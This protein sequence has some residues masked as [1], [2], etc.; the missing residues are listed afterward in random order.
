MRYDSFKVLIAMSVSFLMVFIAFTPFTPFTT[1]VDESAPSGT[2]GAAICQGDQCKRPYEDAGQ[3]YTEILSQPTT[4]SSR[5][6]VNKY[7]VLAGISDYPGSGSDLQYCDDDVYD[8]RDKLVELGWSNTNIHLLIDGQ[9]TNQN[10]LSE[11]AWM[12]QQENVNSQV[13]FHF[14]GH[15]N[16]GTFMTYGSTMTDDTLANAFNGFESTQR[17]I[18]MDTCFA[19]SFTSLNMANTISIMACQN[20]QFSYDGVFTPTFVNKMPNASTSVE[21][22]FNDAKT[23]VSQQTG[24]NQVPLMWDN[25]AGNLLLGN[26]PPVIGA[27][28]AFS[29]EEDTPIVMDLTAYESD[30]EDTGPDLDWFVTDYDAGIIISITGEQSDDDVITLYPETD[31]TGSTNIELSLFDSMGQSTDR[32]VSVTWTPVNDPPTVASLDRSKSVLKRT[33]SLVF[34]LFGNDVDDLPNQVTAEIEVSPEGQ[35]EWVPTSSSQYVQGH[36]ETKWTPFETDELGMYDVRARLIDKVGLESDWIVRGSLIEVQNNRPQITSI[37][38][39]FNGVERSGNITLSIYGEDVEDQVDAMTAQLEYL[40]PGGL[41]MSAGTAVLSIG[42]WDVDFAPGIEAPLGWYDLRAQVTDADGDT[43]PWFYEN[44]SIE[45]QNSRP[46]VTSIVPEET[47]V[48]RDS[49]INIEV[50]GWDPEDSNINLLAELQF[51]APDGEWLDMSDTIEFS[52]D[53][54]WATFLPETGYE[55]GQ[56]SFR[57]RLVDTA[58]AI[59]DWYMLEDGVDVLNNIPLVEAIESNTLSV[60]RTDDMEVTIKVMDVEDPIYNLT[61]E[62]ELSPDGKEAWDS[63]IVSSVEWSGAKERWVVILSPDAHVTPGD[64]QLRVRFTDLDGSIGEW[65]VFEE[66]ITIMNGPPVINLQYPDLVNEK[67]DVTFDASGSNDPEGGALQYSWDFGDGGSDSSDKPVHRFKKHGTYYLTL[68]VKDI[69]GAE[70]TETVTLKINGL[71]VAVLDATQDAGIN[72]FL[73]KFTSEGSN[74][75]DGSIAS[76]RWDFDTTKDTNG[77][78]D[79]AN[80]IDSTERNPSYDYEKEGTFTYKL[81]LVDDKGASTEVVR[82]I[83]IST[84]STMTAGLIGGISLIIVIAAIS[85]IVLMRRKRGGKKSPEVEQAA[86]V[87]GPTEPQSDRYS[88][89]DGE[90][91][92]LFK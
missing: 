9:A 42:H 7:A 51:S 38:I 1:N 34:K 91:D 73:V 16:S 11:I 35:A 53:H 25:I 21:K 39:P 43:S 36:W 5:D 31:Y 44:G 15:G 86:R 32:S 71:P 87:H 57:A 80:D 82:D 72:N 79:P 13:Y 68:K 37:F 77:D 29:S 26:L 74:D 76:Y 78:G 46:F 67:T 75:P 2:R 30:A 69:D 17:V 63:S 92:K 65:K 85:A 83:T 8:T 4:T 14:S 58:G 40:P 54:W 12:K 41:F 20:N 24:G 52:N 88:L 3:L 19:G 90:D 60:Q 45:V 23:S 48:L 64:Y 28:P 59:S 50:D 33:Q 56:Y 10:I 70:V 81:V 55:T 61:P 66:K 62:A 49:M 47:S 84:M 6:S 18:V 27:I 89:L 22:A